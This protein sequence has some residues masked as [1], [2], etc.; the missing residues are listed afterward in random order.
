MLTDTHTL[1]ESEADVGAKAEFHYVAN[2][3]CRTGGG[4]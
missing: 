1:V 3:F 4:S 2:F